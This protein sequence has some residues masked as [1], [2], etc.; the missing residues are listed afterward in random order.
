MIQVKWYSRILKDFLKAGS[1][2][3]RESR[4]VLERKSEEQRLL[5]DNIKTQVWYLS[6]AGTYGRVNRAHADFLGFHPR[7]IAYRKLEDFLSPDVAA[8]CRS[9]NQAVFDKKE[10]IYS[11][12]WVP[13]ARGE[14]RLIRIIKT[15][16]R[17]KKGQVEFV[18]CTGEDITGQRQ[19]EKTGS[20]NPAFA[21]NREPGPHGRGRSPPLQQHAVSRVGVP[22]NGHG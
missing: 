1:G 9:S 7:E 21:E 19:T 10:T 12:E 20:Q 2:K 13:D 5:L 16:K 6:D 15:P 4:D 17:N 3:T 8:V 22:G 18:V 11:E 14:K